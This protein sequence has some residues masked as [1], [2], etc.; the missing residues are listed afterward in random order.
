M[1]SREQL[2][3]LYR[4]F[5][6]AE[7]VS[8]ATLAQFVQ[9]NGESAETISRDLRLGLDPLGKWVIT[10]SIGCGKSSELLKLADLLREDYA[11][12]PLD[13]PNSVA[14]VD[15]L[16]PAEILFLAGA[17]TVKAA[18]DLWG[19]EIEIASQNRLIKAFSRLVPDRDLDLNS[20]F[21]GVALFLGD[22]VVPGAG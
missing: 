10:G 13:L 9:R 21:E 16:Q 17:A 22:L 1:P 15:M 5:D 3:Q 14:R 2:V 7:P 20:V 8:Q 12:V 19:H 6:P 4:D 18:R 11:V